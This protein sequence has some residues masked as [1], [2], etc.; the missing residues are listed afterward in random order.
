ML[1]KPFP[2]SLPQEEDWRPARRSPSPPTHVNVERKRDN[3]K[4]L[5]R[6]GQRFVHGFPLGTTSEQIR[7]IFE[8]F[9]QVVDVTFGV[10]RVTKR[11]KN[12][13]FVEFRNPVH[14][15]EAM[16]AL[17][18]TLVGGMKIDIE[19]TTSQ[20]GYPPTAAATASTASL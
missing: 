18:G 19:R 4:S 7:E 16:Y 14:A 5:S 2:R 13:C 8:P 12:H 3:E 6:P 20:P 11:P 15:E 1:A 17:K 9:G 10:N